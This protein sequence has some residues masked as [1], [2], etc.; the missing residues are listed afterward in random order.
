[1]SGSGASSGVVE[2]A[3]LAGPPQVMG[4]GEL[5]PPRG[6]RSPA[7]LLEVERDLNGSLSLSLPFIQRQMY[8]QSFGPVV[9][10]PPAEWTDGGVGVAAPTGLGSSGPP[11][12]ILSGLP[13]AKDA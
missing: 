11:R 1:M 3:W 8:A 5:D 9:T 10:P 12:V 4:N 13:G 2:V 7:A 6:R